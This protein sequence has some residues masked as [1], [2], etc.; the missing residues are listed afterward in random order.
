MEGELA[1]DGRAPAPVRQLPSQLIDQIAAGEVVERPAS[2]VKELVENA[3][4]AGASRIRVE[5]RGGGVDWIAV[6]DDGFGMA[7]P[8]AR[9]ALQRHATSKIQSVADL[10]AIASFGFRGEA[11]PAIA[12]VSRFRLRT[13]AREAA[14]GFELRV[15]G[16]RVVEA[17]SASGAEGT[18]VEVADLFLQVPARR[19]F[20][21]RAA[22]EWRHCADWLA[23]AALALPAVHFDVYRDEREAIAWPAVDDPLDRIAAVLS[24]REAEGL[25]PVTADTGPM[26]LHG[27]ASRPEAHRPT[28]ASLYLYVNGRPVRDRLLRHALLDVYSD[29]LP[30]GRY[31][32]AVLFVEIDP[33]RV[34]V[35]VHPA[36][37][38]VRF[39]D[40]QAVHHATTQALRATLG[41]RGWLGGA[42]ST[43]RPRSHA[44]TP[45]TPSAGAPRT[46]A[47]YGRGGGAGDG[48]QRT[49]EGSSDWIFAGSGEF[50]AAAL[51]DA[52]R[53]PQNLDAA[54][55]AERAGLRFA[56][57]PLLGQL[58]ATYVLLEGPAGLLLIDQH[59]AH[60]CVLYEQLRSGFRAGRVPRQALLMPV[61]VELTPTLAARL[62]DFSPAAEAF[63]FELEP[64]GENEIVV[65]ATPALLERGD[66]AALV[67]Q[68]AEELGSRELRSAELRAPA[69]AEALF[70]SLACHS[71]RRAGERLH[72]DEQVALLQA[73][74]GI[75]WSP[76]CPHGR[77]VAIDLP[78]GEIER[79]FGRT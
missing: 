28:A 67:A 13:R 37:W 71:A 48:T 20:L 73:L 39:T 42:T 21:K 78:V 1:G 51:P 32:T 60:E 68:L 55:A 44:A 22:T 57:L 9:R 7:E 3:L 49:A 24:D 31:P 15:E 64:F 18:R 75:P 47:D 27:Y 30:R 62:R 38:E 4:D 17:K 23:R 56:T 40:P 12:S 36:K 63:G 29:V 10:H 43:P 41:D 74:D 61:T 46:A 50:P 65:R 8:D 54:P 77:P 45:P 52:A 35:N 70:A 79:R 6:R 19:K 33:A 16:G 76:T 34:D 58:R 53:P 69:A 25:I 11:L 26:R 72:R 59:A 5:L 14:E 2:V 66:P